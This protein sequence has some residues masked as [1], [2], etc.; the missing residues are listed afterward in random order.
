[1]VRLKIRSVETI[2]SV[3]NLKVIVKFSKEIVQALINCEFIFFIY[4]I[5]KGDFLHL[6]RCSSTGKGPN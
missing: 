6:L 5:V 4:C 2:R 3:L 1:M